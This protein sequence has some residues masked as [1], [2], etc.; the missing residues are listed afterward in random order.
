MPAV[1]SSLGPGASVTAYL[2]S[3]SR[4]QT[5]GDHELYHGFRYGCRRS[6]DGTYGAYHRVHRHFSIALS[7]IIRGANDVSKLA[8]IRY[9][10]RRFRPLN[11]DLHMIPVERWRRHAAQP[12]KPPCRSSELAA[13]NERVRSLAAMLRQSIELGT[14]VGDA[15]RAFSDDMRDRRLCGLR[16]APTN[17]P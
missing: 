12:L 9:H 5:R 1:T 3:I 6:T 11:N 16:S 13:L 14:D 2:R 15:L 8:R 4:H 10:F 17:F 7:R